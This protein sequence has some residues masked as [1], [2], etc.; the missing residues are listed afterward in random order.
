MN[1]P[2]VLE[3]LL[4]VRE[5]MVDLQREG[6]I[7]IQGFTWGF[8]KSGV[9]VTIEVEIRKTREYVCRSFTGK[10]AEGAVLQALGLLDQIEKL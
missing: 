10:Y 2:T 4:P 7:V 9:Y 3:A 8:E 6:K 5:K 1:K